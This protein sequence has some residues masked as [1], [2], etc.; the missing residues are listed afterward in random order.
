[1]LCYFI[2]LPKYGSNLEETLHYR[3]GWAKVPIQ[4]NEL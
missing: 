2:F 3:T 4:V 1:M